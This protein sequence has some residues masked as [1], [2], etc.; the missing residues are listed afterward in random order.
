M[1]FSVSFDFVISKSIRNC[2]LTMHVLVCDIET[3]QKTFVVS[4]AKRG[5]EYQ[6]RRDVVHNPP[7]QTQGQA[8]VVRRHSD[9]SLLR[10][11]RGR[12]ADQGMSYLESRQ[13]SCTHVR[14]HARR[15][16]HTRRHAAARTQAQTR[17][18][19]AHSHARVR[20]FTHIHAHHTPPP[21]THPP[22]HNHTQSRPR[23]PLM[24]ARLRTL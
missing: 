6:R 7:R 12:P 8:N 9:V 5:W 20:A 18:P 23:M 4:C 13:K 22:N 1:W 15:H 24:A 14:T 19:R 10:R 16:A 21:T 2:C 11:E 3:Y 17:A